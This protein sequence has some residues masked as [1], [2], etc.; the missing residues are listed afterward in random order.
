MTKEMINYQ[1]IYEDELS[2]TVRDSLELPRGFFELSHQ[3]RLLIEEMIDAGYQRAVEDVLDPEVINDTAALA[4]EM[5]TQLYNFANM[6]GN[7]LDEA[8]FSEEN[9]NV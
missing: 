9:E 3:K 6:L 8:K 1:Q 7:Y 2:E 5:G 4:A